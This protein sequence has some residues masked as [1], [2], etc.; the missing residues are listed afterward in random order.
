MSQLKRVLT[1]ALP[2][3]RNAIELDPNEAHHLTKVLRLK[4]GDQVE[5]FDGKGSVA[6]VTLRV[7]GASVSILALESEARL[8]SPLTQSTP[9][10]PVTLEMA[11]IKGEAMEWVVEKAVELGIQKLRPIVTDYGVVQIQKKGPEAFQERWQRIADQALKQCGR[12]HRLEV[13]F[14][15]TLGDLFASGSSGLRL[16]CD[17]RGKPLD[18]EPAV[19]LLQAFEAQSFSLK[20]S[21][22]LL[23]GPEG[24]FSPAER[25]LLTREGVARVHLGP[26]VLRAETAALFAMS[27]AN[28][29]VWAHERL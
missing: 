2:H 18:A 15:V 17:E 13:E 28:G 12:T 21:L 22:N 5:A 24:G 8:H 29:Y 27:V 16:W 7:R 6:L 10:L 19:P 26:L 11:I 9:T 3:G 25:E 4:D 14:P 23:I 1:P 20:S